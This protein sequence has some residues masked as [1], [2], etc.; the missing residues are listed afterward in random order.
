MIEVTNWIQENIS[1]VDAGDVRRRLKGA[2]NFKSAENEI[3]KQESPITGKYTLL[4]FSIKE[5]GRTAEVM[6]RY[7][8]DI[9]K[10]YSEYLAQ[11]LTDRLRANYDFDILEEEE[12]EALVNYGK[13]LMHELENLCSRDVF[14]TLTGLYKVF[15]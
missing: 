14:Y 2:I 11:A 12:Y 6:F 5:L 13:F 1:N 15:K 3:L 10:I 7:E 8:G 9:E 4:G